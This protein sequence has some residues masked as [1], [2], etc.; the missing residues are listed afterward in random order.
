MENSPGYAKY[1]PKTT[2]NNL[3]KA[4]SAT[5]LEQIIEEIKRAEHYSQQNP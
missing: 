2:Q 3:L 4:T 5:I 1:T